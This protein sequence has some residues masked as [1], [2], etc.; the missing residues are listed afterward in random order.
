MK[1]RQMLTVKVVEEKFIIFFLRHL[2]YKFVLKKFVTFNSFHLLSVYYPEWVK[3]LTNNEI[4]RAVNTIKSNYP[5]LIGIPL[6]Y[7]IYVTTNTFWDWIDSAWMIFS[8]STNFLLG[9]ETNFTFF[10]IRVR[11][12]CHTNWKTSTVYKKQYFGNRNVF[13]KTLDFSFSK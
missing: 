8:M 3:H 7:S 9:V 13:I 4:D 10:F 1:R 11:N 2:K 12:I 5:N 6:L